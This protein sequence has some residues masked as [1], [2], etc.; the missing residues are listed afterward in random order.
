MLQNP[1]WSDAGPHLVRRDANK[2]IDEHLLFYASALPVYIDKFRTKE[3]IEWAGNFLGWSF[4][5]LLVVASVLVVYWCF[6]F[7]FVGSQSPVTLARPR[8]YWM[9]L[10]GV[11]CFTCVT[12]DGASRCSI[13]CKIQEW[14]F[15][16]SLQKKSVKVMSRRMLRHYHY[17]VLSQLPLLSHWNNLYH[18]NW[19]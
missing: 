6:N 3:G 1:S 15:H 12:L 18:L 5:N 9:K 19:R 17:Q 8:D 7:G 16:I 13:V 2:R 14:L 4:T 10:W 11:G